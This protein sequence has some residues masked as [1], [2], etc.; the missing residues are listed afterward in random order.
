MHKRLSYVPE[1]S[2]ISNCGTPAEKV[3]EFLDNQLQLIM[4]KDLSCM[5]DADDFI[6]NIG[7]WMRYL[8]II[9][10]HK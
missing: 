4:R 1:R 6:N 8:I 5:K 9:F 7:E 10:D 2:V 3:S